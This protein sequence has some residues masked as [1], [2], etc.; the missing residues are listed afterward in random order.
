MWLNTTYG[1]FIIITQIKSKEIIARSNSFHFNN[2]Y[3]SFTNNTSS[4]LPLTTP[5]PL[6]LF[7]SLYCSIFF[8]LF[9]FN[10]ILIDTGILSCKCSYSINI[11]DYSSEIK[12]LKCQFGNNFLMIYG[13]KYPKLYRIG[14]YPRME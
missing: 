4:S 2:K 6:L 11:R 12:P 8:L 1:L 14:F 13:I 10:T 9:K 3:T 7:P 5:S